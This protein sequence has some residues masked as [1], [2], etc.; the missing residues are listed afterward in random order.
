MRC[1]IKDHAIDD[2]GKKA[3]RQH[4]NRQG[5]QNN[6]RFQKNVQ[7]AD[8]QRRQQQV[9]KAVDL[10]SGDQFHY[11]KESEGI[12]RPFEYKSCHSISTLQPA[13]LSE[14]CHHHL[15]LSDHKAPEHEIAVLPL[16]FRKVFEVH[17]VDPY[18]KGQR[19]EDCADH[20]QKLHHLV[21]AVADAGKVEIKHAGEQVAVCLYR[22]DYLNGVIVDIPEIEPGVIMQQRAVAPFQE[23]DRLA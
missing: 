10:N 20:G 21:G 18:Q 3:K 17:A 11:D 16:Q 6:N 9:L 23:R 22:I 12:E 8:N 1:Q 19:H 7:Q 13:F 14:I 5:K 15:R 2:E 4:C